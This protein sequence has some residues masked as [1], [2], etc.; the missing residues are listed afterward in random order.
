MAKKARKAKKPQG[1]KAFDDLTRKV[2]AVPKEE[3]DRL[4][5]AR[6][7]RESKK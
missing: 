3:V 6:P 1:W 5:A 7:K 2:V 4:E